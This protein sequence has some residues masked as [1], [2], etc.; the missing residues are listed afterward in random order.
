MR[1]EVR[2]G[3]GTIEFEERATGFRLRSA[4]KY[5]QAL[6]AMSGTRHFEI[7]DL[8]AGRTVLSAAA[9]I[10]NSKSPIFALAGFFESAGRVCDCFAIDPRISRPL[11]EQ[12]DSN[13]A[14]LLGIADGEMAQLGVITAKVAKE[15]RSE[16]YWN[17]VW[18]G[19]TADL[20]LDNDGFALQFLDTMIETGPFSLV[21]SVRPTDSEKMRCL[22]NETHEGDLVN[23]SFEPV[24]P[25]KVL[26]AAACKNRETNSA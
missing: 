11:T 23:V 25:A 18:Q 21:V 2:E 1:L 24:L 22:W 6:Q 20:R 5:V 19:E 15:A 14:F 17:R 4:W 9:N 12:E 16:A 13:F 3:D 26:R 7:Y 10:E 8:Q